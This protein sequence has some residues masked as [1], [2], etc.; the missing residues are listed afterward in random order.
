[1]CK[2]PTQLKWKLQMNCLN[3]FKKIMKKNQI[4]NPTIQFNVLKRNMLTHTQNPIM[5]EIA[6]NNPFLPF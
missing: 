3:S 1:M 5:L 2:N 4:P 6:N